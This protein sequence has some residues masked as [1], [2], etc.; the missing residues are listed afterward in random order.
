MRPVEPFPVEGSAAV[1]FGRDQPEYSPLP[2]LVFPDHTILVE[3]ELDD[4]DRAR[5]ARG[6]S[7]H[8]WIYKPPH[9]CRRCGDQSHIPLQP[10]RIE[11]PNERQG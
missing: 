4:E 6:E 8:L 1:V 2:A 11:I 7:L 3:Y 10:V 9:T 5:L